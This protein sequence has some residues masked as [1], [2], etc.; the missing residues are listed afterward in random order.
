MSFNIPI[1]LITFK[2]IETTIAVLRRISECKPSKIYISSNYGKSSEEIIIVERLRSNILSEID[3]KCEVH[4]LNRSVHLSAKESIHTAIDWFFESEK[5]G[6]ILEDDC[7]PSVSFFYFCEKL[8]NKYQ[9]DKRV[10]HISGTCVLDE[11]DLLNNDSFYFSNYCHIW[12]WASWSDRWK[13]YDPELGQLS[14]FLK[15]N[16][17]ANLF[18]SYLLRSFWIDNFNR[19]FNKKIDTWDYQW[20]MTVWLNNGLSIIPTR[21]LVSNIG[22]NEEATHTTNSDHKLAN[23]E[24]YDIDSEL[25]LPESYMPSKYYDNI[26][27]GY[28]FNLSYVGLIIIKLKSVIKRILGVGND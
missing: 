21:N 13:K 25:I 24:S 12:G 18:E 2:K 20:Y 3:W 1:L 14:Y 7:L 11:N 5:M 26:S 6:I 19:T 16:L 4:T 8:L 27:S 23:L 28:L 15:N 22:F 17:I 9:D 10:W